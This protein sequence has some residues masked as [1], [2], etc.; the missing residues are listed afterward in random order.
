MDF[1]VGLPRSK[2]YTVILVVVDR[3]TKYSHFAPFYPSS[4]RWPKVSSGAQCSRGICLKKS[5]YFTSVLFHQ[6]I[7]DR[8]LQHIL[9]FQALA[10]LDIF[11]AENI[12]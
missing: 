10:L 11:A 12:A 1:I 9:F 3:L 2:G 6:L 4:L 5:I 8:E 7:C